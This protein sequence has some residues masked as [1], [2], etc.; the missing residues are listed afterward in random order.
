MV[1]GPYQRQGYGTAAME[2]LFKHIKAL[3][4]P[5]LYTSYGLGEGSP[6]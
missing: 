2:F 1:A 4:V 5:A 3:G 6:D